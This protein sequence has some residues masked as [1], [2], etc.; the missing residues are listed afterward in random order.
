MTDQGSGSGASDAELRTVSLGVAPMSKAGRLHRWADALA[1]QARLQAEHSASPGARAGARR[2][3]PL[4]IALED[5]AFQAEGLCA[6]RLQDA[7]AFFGLPESEIR[8]LAGMG[9]GL[10]PMPPGMASR[11]LRALAVQ[12]ENERTPP[13]DGRRRWTGER[14]APT[15]ERGSAPSGRALA[16]AGRPAGL[17]TRSRRVAA[18]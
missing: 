7:P 12:A 16:L 9:R 5:W 11:R 8:R 1:L 14:L 6:D 3:S 18:G 10:R 13:E 2:G 4:A 17:R 15:S